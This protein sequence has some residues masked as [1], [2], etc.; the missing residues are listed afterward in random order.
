MPENASDERIGCSSS[1]ARS[2]VFSPGRK[3]TNGSIEVAVPSR[4]TTAT[5]CR[6]STGTRRTRGRT[7]R[8]PGRRSSATCPEVTYFVA[9]LG[10]GGTLTGVGRRLHA[11]DPASRSSR[12]SRSSGDLVYGLRSLEEGFIPPIFDETVLDRKFLVNSADSLAGHARADREGRDL[13]RHLLRRGRARRPADRRPSSTTAT[14][15]A[16]SPTAA[17]STCRPKLGR[18][19]STCG[20]GRRGDPLVV[21]ACPIDRPIGLFDS[22]CRR[23]HRRS[24]HPRPPSER[25]DR[26][27]RRQRAVPLRAEAARGDPFLRARDRRVPRVRDVKM[28]VVAC[29][30]IEVAAI[31]D[32]AEAHAVPVIGVIDPGTRAAVHATVTAGSG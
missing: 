4:R 2:I 30:S 5:T 12:P 23:S 27:R 7:T 21:D 14:S 6:S 8:G 29:N 17:G 32:V 13:R 19:S 26:L 24:R 16:C 9:G 28:L 1:S 20:E 22:G 15:S 11:H 31:A 18:R 10:T 3:G 25:A